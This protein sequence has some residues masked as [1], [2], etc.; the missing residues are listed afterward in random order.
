MSW[1]VGYKP[2]LI[3]VFPGLNFHTLGFFSGTVV[4][5]LGDAVKDNNANQKNLYDL[6]GCNK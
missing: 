6:V 4:F 2:P 3:A 1:I 5:R